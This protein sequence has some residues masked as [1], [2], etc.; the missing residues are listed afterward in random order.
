MK[1]LSLQFIPRGKSGWESPLLQFGERTTSLYA[2]NESG[3]T[4]L[5]QGMAFCLGY[6]TTFREDIKDQCSAIELTIEY[7]GSQY[8]FSRD[9]G[10]DFHLVVRTATTTREYFNEADFSSALFQTFGMK[11]PVLVGSNKKSTQ[12]YVSTVFPIFYVRQDGGYLE[13][14]RPS[15]TFIQDQFVEMIRFVFGLPPKRSYEAAK[16]LLKAKEQLEIAQQRYV[17]QQRVVADL[18]AS[19]DD[20]LQNKKI[21]DE[22]SSSLSKQLDE[23]RE[24]A[25]SKGAA[26]DALHDLLAVKEEQ[27]RATRRQQFE[28]RTRVAGIDSIRSEIQGERTTLSLNEEA[29][30]ALEN[31]LDICQRPDCGLFLSSSESYAKNL[32][33]LKDQL[34]DLESNSARAEIQLE[35]IERRLQTEENERVLILSKLEKNAA[36][37]GTGTLIEAVQTLTK[38]LLDVERKR[39]SIQVLSEERRKYIQFDNDRSTLHDRI[40]TLSNNGR[41]DVEFSKLRLKIRN[42]VIRWMEIIHVV[43]ISRDVSIDHNFKFMFGNETMEPFTGSGRARVVLA[44]HAAIFEAYLEEPDNPF[45]F[46]V[47]DTPKQHELNGDDLA[48]YL[49]ELYAVCVR[50]NGQVIISSTEYQHV[51]ESGDV[52]W[53]PSYPG[54]EQ[55]M[56][57]GTPGTR[58]P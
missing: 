25:D 32:L 45:R 47:L 39:V 43:N 27:I 16:D 3:K 20:S 31:F 8:R 2:E 24:S 51:L 44:I 26:K 17:L 34:K 28:L 40:A 55:P 42:Y 53:R 9:I 30:R 22:L 29:K 19:V 6:H 54:K 4:P 49:K 10:N 38:Q 12:P 5:M 21:L 46:M 1:L 35:E 50:L 37:D 14:Y 7:Q 18:S 15:N 56:Y 36:S 11:P 33:Y 57:L 48:R 41:L 58:L 13:P 23:L 52:E